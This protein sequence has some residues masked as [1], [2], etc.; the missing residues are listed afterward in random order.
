MQRRD[1][2]V[3]NFYIIVSQ[4]GTTGLRLVGHAEKPIQNEEAWTV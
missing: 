4:A 2:R 1:F 3:L